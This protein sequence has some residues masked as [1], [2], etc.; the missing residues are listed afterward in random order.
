MARS[1][2]ERIPQPSIPERGDEREKRTRKKRAAPK[3][4]REKMTVSDRPKGW[5]LEKPTEPQKPEPVTPEQWERMPEALRERYQ[6]QVRAYE[7][8]EK[9]TKNW[10]PTG[11]LDPRY[12]NRDLKPKPTPPKTVSVEGLRS[13][14]L[15]EHI[16]GNLVSLDGLEGD[17]RRDMAAHNAMV[18][19][20]YKKALAHYFWHDMP[21]QM[22]QGTNDP[23]Y[24]DYKRLRDKKGLVER[25]KDLEKLK[26]GNKPIMHFLRKYLI[27]RPG[28]ALAYAAAA[29]GGPMGASAYG[30]AKVNSARERAL[31][32]AYQEHMERER[33]IIEA[34]DARVLRGEDAAAALAYIDGLWDT[35][36]KSRIARGRD[37]GVRRAE[38]NAL[39]Q[40]ELAE[41]RVHRLELD[42]SMLESMGLQQ[43]DYNELSIIE[44]IT[45]ETR[46]DWQAYGQEFGL[47]SVELD[48]AQRAARFITP[49]MIE[50]VFLNELEAEGSGERNV[51]GW[52]RRLHTV[53][54]AV[55]LTP[56]QGDR[57]SIVGPGQETLTLDEDQSIG[58]MSEHI[59]GDAYW[60]LNLSDGFTDMRGTAE[61]AQHVDFRTS[62]ETNARIPRSLKEE[63]VEILLNAMYN[64][65]M[66]VRDPQ[67][68][69]A[70]ELLMNTASSAGANRQL[71]MLRF[72]EFVIMSH[73]NPRETSAA[74]D[75]WYGHGAN[76]A[77]SI[78][79][80][81]PDDSVIQDYGIRVVMNFPAMNEYEHNLRLQ[82]E[83]VRVPTESERF[84][85][86]LEEIR[87]GRRQ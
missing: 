60:Y 6:E 79:S 40:Q 31:A 10:S 52:A 23:V 84:E 34:E 5:K 3:D 28:F 38:V 18:R 50:T 8:Y 32:Q 49:A 82:H 14:A 57:Y 43:S 39:L 77:V 37:T 58:R 46:F 16:Q 78:H 63:R 20:D 12:L 75:R 15:E 19:E 35:K 9:R 85:R 68:R 61:R 62:L 83:N 2:A 59:A 51:E 4:E 25:K 56:T 87:S 13:P 1:G 21:V 44:A 33:Q 73:N 17:F 76:F 11:I 24:Q 45:G 27:T 74:L 86:I 81:T 65:G 72:A 7:R 41:G 48:T 55:A 36:M 22:R 66:A 71:A 29:I 53:G 54:E 42:Q 64:I 80:F 69:A 67:Q 70:L 30:D 26:R 47:S